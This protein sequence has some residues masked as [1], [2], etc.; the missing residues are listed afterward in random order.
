[1]S[2]TFSNLKFEI[3]GN[4]EQSGSWGT[5]T[6]VNIGTA[7]EQAIV[8][9]ATLD[10]GD[11]TANVATLTLTNTNAAQDAR[12][13]CLNIAA[14]AVSAAGTINV[15]AIEKPYIVINGSSYTVTVKVSGQTGV[16]VPAGKRTV[17]YNNGTDVGGQIDWLNSLTLG[18][19]LPVASGGTGSATLTANNVLLGNGTSALQVV[20]PGTTGNVLTSNGTTWSSAA[21]PAGGLT[22]IYTTTPVTATD[23]QGVLADTSGGSFTVTLPATPSTGAQVVVADAGSSWGTN[24]LTVARNGSTINGTAE[25]LVCDISG[26]SVQFVYDG[27]TWEVY[28][29]VGGNGGSVVT[30]TGVQTLTNKTLTAPTLTT[31]VLG[32]PASGTL[33][34]CTVDGTNSVGYLNIPQNSQSAAY[35]LVA[36]DAGKHIL[37]PS[38]DANARTFTIPANSSVAYPIGTAITFVNMTSQVVT[39]AI[40][41]DTLTLSSAGTSGSRSLAQYGS[42][43]ALKIGSTQWLISGSGLT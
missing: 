2:S 15:P 20:A 43:T 36:A 33:S 35:T 28:A 24:N 29:Q 27:T 23:K 42:A 18:T 41:S 38:T 19:A 9:M 25:N 31:P 14:G 8:G 34:N 40:T 13:L 4:G 17:V 6:N 37:H 7:I 1:M 11:F 30:L 32:T 12:A 26:V 10:S 16:A 21:L 22:Y 39:I 5:T 3:I